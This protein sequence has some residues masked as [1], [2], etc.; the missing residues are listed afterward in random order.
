MC[1]HRF[2]I[3]KGIVKQNILPTYLVSTK[4]LD[5]IMKNLYLT[6]ARQVKGL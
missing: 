6:D 4:A 1:Q 3:H 5:V 2:S